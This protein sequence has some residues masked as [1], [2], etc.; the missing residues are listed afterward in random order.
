M[1]KFEGESKDGRM[2]KTNEVSGEGTEGFC[3]RDGGFARAAGRHG[4]RWGCEWPGVV[5]S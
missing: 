5:G 1:G 4:S 2:G 3:A